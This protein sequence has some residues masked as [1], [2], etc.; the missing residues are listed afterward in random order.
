MS[1]EVRYTKQALKSLK[2]LDKIACVLLVSWIEK[3]LVGTQNPRLKG[4]AL[5]ANLAEAWRYRVGEYRLIAH[6]NDEKSIILLLD[7]GHRKD[8]YKDF[9]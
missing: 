7:I 8:I 6:I 2:K 1:Y 9:S 3:H 4:K 5:R